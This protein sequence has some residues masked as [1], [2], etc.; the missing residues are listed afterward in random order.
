MQSFRRLLAVSQIPQTAFLTPL[1][2]TTAP[3]NYDQFV[4]EGYSGV[5]QVPNISTNEGYTTG[6]QFATDRRINSWV[7]EL[8]SSEQMSFQSLYRRMFGAMSGGSE[9]NSVV[10]A[11]AN[12]HVMTIQGA[13]ACGSASTA[14]AYS[15][16]DKACEQPVLADV[17]YDRL[18]VGMCIESL[19]FNI[20]GTD[21]TPM[22]IQWRGSGRLLKRSAVQLTPNF[23]TNVKAQS[24][25]GYKWISKA[26]AALRFFPQA[27]LAGAPYLP[28]CNVRSLQMQIQN[29]F[30]TTNGYCGD[31]NDPANPDSGGV[32]G[33][34][35]VQRTVVS[36]TAVVV[37]PK[38]ATFDFYEYFEKQLPLSMDLTYTGGNIGATATPYSAKFDFSKVVFTGATLDD[39]DGELAFNLPFEILAEGSTNPFTFT[40]VNEI[41]SATVAA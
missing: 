1:A 27:G 31:T 10:I 26:N 6:S 24:E 28:A 9:T 14:P 16:A 4:K 35:P 40:T 21:L 30:D 32:L 17:V 12:Q 13:A 3:K 39:S 23:F 36:G 15:I 8:Q 22:E 34:M 19:S 33:S 37:A 5:S 25:L 11:G 18:A 7:T 2:P 41:T 20:Q 38:I 29:T